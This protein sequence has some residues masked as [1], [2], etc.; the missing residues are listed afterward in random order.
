MGRGPRVAPLG[1]VL[2]GY[3]LCLG[4]LE[5]TPIVPR[6][7]TATTRIS[8]L[9]VFAT[10][11][12]YPTLRLRSIETGSVGAGLGLVGVTADFD[13]HAGPRSHRR[14]GSPSSFGSFSSSTFMGTAT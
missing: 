3:G 1:A 4:S 14:F 9:G 10:P 12:V 5:A 13:R 11:P 2:V 7:V 6:W 8:L